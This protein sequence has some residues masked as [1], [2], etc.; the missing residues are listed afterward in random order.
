[1]MKLAI[2]ISAVLLPRAKVVILIGVD[3]EAYFVEL[4]FVEVSVVVSS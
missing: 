3:I 2:A 4:I 1:M